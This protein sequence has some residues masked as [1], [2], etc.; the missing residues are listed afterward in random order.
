[1]STLPPRRGT[2]THTPRW[3]FAVGACVLLV[4]SGII[5]V[6]VITGK[7][8]KSTNDGSVIVSD[9]TTTT[10]ESGP[11]RTRHLDG[12]LVPMGEEALPV[13]AVMID[14][15]I[16]ARPWSGVSEAN[17]VIEAPVEGGITRLM[18]FFDATSTVEKIGPVRS[19]RPYFVDWAQGWGAMYTHV[20]GSDEALNKIKN[21]GKNIHDLNEMLIGRYFWRDSNRV[22]PH[23]TYTKSDLLNEAALRYGATSSAP[24]VWQ[25]QDPTTSTPATLSRVSI[26]YGGSY[27]VNWLFDQQTGLYTRRIGTKTQRDA[28]GHELLA[29]NVV[30]IKTDSQVL[31]SYGRLRVRTTGSGDA[32]IYRNGQKYP[33]RWLRSAGEPIR[34][35][36]ADG[37]DM[38]L[39]RGTT[40][41]QVTTDD[42]TF[43]GSMSTSTR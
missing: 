2:S 20:G 23:S 31:D 38:A 17:L 37:T 9:T 24:L 12:A 21:L 8:R 19:A 13:R 10:V 28:E 26:A 25:F 34:F 16:D 35:Q 3:L 39:N 15:Q 18:A 1:M 14:N 42:L 22:S 36:G 7:T 27:S 33:T 5:L 11:L 30:L 6:F 43:G 41:I 40:W 4:V 32:I 29:S